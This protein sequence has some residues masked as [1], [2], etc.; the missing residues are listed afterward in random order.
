MAL[1]RPVE[2]S[3]TVLCNRYNIGFFFFV[4]TRHQRYAGVAHERLGSSAGLDTEAVH[5]LPPC[6]THWVAFYTILV[7]APNALHIYRSVHEQVG[8]HIL[9]DVGVVVL[10]RQ[11]TVIVTYNLQPLLVMYQF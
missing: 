1:F 4:G 5:G 8:Y 3:L 7:F 11:L 6:S 10:P 9:M 2:P